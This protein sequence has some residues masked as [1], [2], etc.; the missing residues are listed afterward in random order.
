VACSSKDEGDTAQAPKQACESK[1]DLEFPDGTW[2]SFG[3]C[4]DVL[5]DATFEFDPDDPPEVR[6]FRIQ[7]AG[8]DEPGFECWLIMTATGICGPGYYDVGPG[9]STSVQYEIPDCPY[10][11]D[12]FEA[13]YSADEGIL[14]LDEASAG[15]EPGNFTDEPVLTR[16]TGALE[17]TDTTGVQADVT[18]DLSVFIRGEDAEE[19]ECDKAD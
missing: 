11:T 2:A 14:L 15:S 5:A 6:S 8:Q 9:Q 1:V 13:A 18:F 19:T 12:G 16:L 7:L 4:N 3:G 17:T 10:V